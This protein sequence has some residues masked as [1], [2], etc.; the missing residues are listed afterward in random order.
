MQLPNGPAK[1][2]LQNDFK[3]KY[4]SLERYYVKLESKFI[5]IIV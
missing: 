5:N 1:I 3:T 4:T 2:N